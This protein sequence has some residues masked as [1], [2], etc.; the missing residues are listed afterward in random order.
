LGKL[1]ILEGTFGQRAGF[2]GRHFGG[3]VGGPNLRL[4]GLRKPLGPGFLGELSRDCAPKEAFTGH[5]IGVF[6]PR[7]FS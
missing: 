5:H 4:F 6:Y 2:I 7:I 1:L 3:M